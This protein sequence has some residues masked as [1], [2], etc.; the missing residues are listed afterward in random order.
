MNYQEMKF[1]PYTNQGQNCSL[2]LYFYNVV[3]DNFFLFFFLVLLTSCL[4]FIVHFYFLKC[5][6]QHI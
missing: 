3:V 4:K 2:M 6:Q 5:L 1:V